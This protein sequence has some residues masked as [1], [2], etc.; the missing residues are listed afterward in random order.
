MSTKIRIALIEANRIFRLGLKKLITDEVIDIVGEASTGSAGM[1]LIRK[2]Q[3]E[4]VLL[5]NDL[6]DVTANSFCEWMHRHFTQTKIII[7][8]KNADMAILNRLLNTSAKGFLTKDSNYLNAEIIKTIAKG[9]TYLQPDLG[10]DVIQHSSPTDILTDREYQVLMLIT[11]GHTHERIA[12]QLRISLKTVFN[13]K[14]RG[15]KKLKVQTMDQ[16]LELW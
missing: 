15:F 7:L 1:E 11:Q 10:L 16:L 4:V 3:P 6:L 5:S 12:E 9:K 13:I 8:L 2:K 14:Y